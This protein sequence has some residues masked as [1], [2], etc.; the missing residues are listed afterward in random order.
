MQQ[1]INENFK[2]M[3]SEE[4]YRNMKTALDSLVHQN[5]KLQQELISGR[6]QMEEFALVKEKYQNDMIELER[7]NF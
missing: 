3:I 7:D 6:E 5:R 4:K 2:S 1:T